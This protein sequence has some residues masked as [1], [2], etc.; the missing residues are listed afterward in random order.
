MP[1]AIVNPATGQTEQTFAP[2]TAA[3]VHHRIGAAASAHL[4][5][6]D[7]SFAQRSAWLHRAA[8]LLDAEVQDT[9]SL[10]TTEMGKPIGQ[11]KAEVHKCARGMRFYADN[12]ED[13]LADTPLPDPSRVG[14]SAAWTRWEPLGVILAVMPWN[15]PLWQVVRFAAPALMAGNTGLLKHASNVPGSALYLEDLLLRAG[16]PVGAFQALL[17]GSE[18][19]AALIDDPR[20]VAVTLT[21]SE[22]AGRSVAARAGSQLKKVVLELG[23]SDPFIV[24]P[25]ADMT[26]AVDTAVT[27]RTLNNGQSCVCG[28]RFIVHTEVYDAFSQMFAERMSHLVVGDPRDLATQIG[29]LAT[30]AGRDELVQLVADAVHLGATVLTGGEAP[31]G[32]GWYY[33]P[34]VL[35]DLTP[36]MRLVTEEAFGPVATLYRVADREEAV[37]VANQTSFGL[38]S[39]LWTTNPEEQTWFTSRIEAGAVF[40][41]GMTVSFPQLPFG[42]VKASGYGRE[43]AA[44][45]IREFCN[46]KTV[47]RA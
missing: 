28:K 10:L 41:N 16:F 35:A 23:G 17:I 15:F 14:A 44:E 39:S 31:A 42:G 13:M 7:T 30:R 5:L 3:E 18:G 34:T 24:M 43:L 8:D 32:E 9:A 36:N 25:S 11:S 38:S 29:P 4:E 22:P 21:G 26:T 2:H 45:G 20:V 40:I 37:A 47:W 27:A 6:R 12:A 33:P 1:I 46:L 19:V